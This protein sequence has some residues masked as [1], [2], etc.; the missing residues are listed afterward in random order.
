MLV[1]HRWLL[2]LHPLTWMGVPA[3]L[4]AP[5]ALALLLVCG[6]AA[7]ALLMVWAHLAGWL[8]GKLSAVGQASLLALC[9]GLAE[10]G[11]SASPLFWIGVGGSVLPLDPWLAALTQ[12]IGAGGLAALL[13]LSS[14][15]LARRHLVIGLLTL[16]LAHGSVSYTHLTLPT[17][18]SV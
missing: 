12:W 16:A 7:A 10:V 18:C 6:L 1:S 9:W 11:L 4:S 15:S 13:L 14:W 8:E 2:G 3:P 17:I 5:I